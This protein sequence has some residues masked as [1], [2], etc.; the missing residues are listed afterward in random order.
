MSLQAGILREG[1][2]DR[3]NRL[4]HKNTLHTYPIYQSN[5][6]RS[7]DAAT[8]RDWPRGEVPFTIRS[9][10]ERKIG[11]VVRNAVEE[12]HRTF[13]GC[14][15][16]KYFHPQRRG[17]YQRHVEFFV[18]RGCFSYIGMKLLVFDLIINDQ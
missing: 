5:K 1:V 12:F 6:S 10:D 17:D 2:Y 7:R 8:F 9:R 14:I 16:W 4:S 13:P 11:G 15:Q 18:G 3:L